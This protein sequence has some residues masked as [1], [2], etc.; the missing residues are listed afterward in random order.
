MVIWFMTSQ[1]VVTIFPQGVQSVQVFY[2]VIPAM[3]AD[4][5]VPV[6][7]AFT[8]LSIQKMS[9]DSAELRLR[10][11]KKTGQSIGRECK[12]LYTAL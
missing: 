9:A 11:F 12:G 4:I 2:L 5:D 3:R 1:L 6:E 8:L 7:G 10:A